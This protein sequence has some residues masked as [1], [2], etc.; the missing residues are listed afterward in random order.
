MNGVGTFTPTGTTLDN[1]I[2]KWVDDNKGIIEFRRWDNR[3]ESDTKWCI[4]AV[5]KITL[6]NETMLA[7]RLKFGNDNE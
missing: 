7:F 3:F 1:P 5:Y 6:N 4:V 2:L